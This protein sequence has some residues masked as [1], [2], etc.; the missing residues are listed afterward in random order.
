MSLWRTITIMTTLLASAV[1][2]QQDASGASS[3]PAGGAGL[4][5]AD[6]IAA[7]Q[8]VGNQA[9]LAKTQLIDVPGQ[10]VNRAIKVTVSPGAT[11]EW[12]VQLRT[13]LAANGAIK[14]GDILL[15][16]FWM[17]CDESMTGD[18]SVGFIVE[19]NH[20]PNDKAVD[21]RINVGSKWTE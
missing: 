16:H 5:P 21:M 4:L 20:P 17:R 11:A 1:I 19:E 7:L 14:S 15:G 12:N 3:I 9:Q 13:P 18:G 6:S 2:S 10:P 8:I